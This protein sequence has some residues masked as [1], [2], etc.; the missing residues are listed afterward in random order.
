MKQNTTYKQTELGLIPD[1][2]EVKKLGEVIKLGNGKDY[3]HLNSG[4][5]PVYGTGGIITYVDK[6]LFNGKSVGIGRKGSIDKP[7]LLDGKFWTVDT[8][9]YVK[10]FFNSD[11]DFIYNSFLKIPWLKYNEAT[12]L[13]SLSQNIINNLKIPLPPLPEQKKIADCL[14]TWDVAIE[15]QSALITALTQRKKAL[16]QQL[17]TGK[18][19]LPGFSDEWKE[20][21]LGDIGEISSAGVDKNI[22]EGEKPIRLLNFLDVYRRDFLYSNEQNHWVTAND[23]KIEKCS[24]KK[25][26]VFFTPSSEVPNDIAISAVAM[27]DFDNVVYSYHIVRFRIKEKWDLRYKAYAFKT[28]EFFKQAQRICDGSGQRYVIS[29][30]N[31]KNI[32][33]KVPS[34]EEQTAIAEILATA[35]RELQLQKEKLAQ[36]QSQKKGLM[37]VLLT[38]KK[39]LIN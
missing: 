32:K 16:M 3:K 4:N 12:G 18:K 28:D 36:L 30:N 22:V 13:P 39:R 19:R 23:Y 8:L 38:G 2:W 14:S 27:E 17:L 10:E 15:K 25:G 11:I 31:F 24:I 5:I 37:Q 9:F 29:Q 26:D 1:D 7:V 33:I 21:K 6:Y 35:D 20:V 34:L